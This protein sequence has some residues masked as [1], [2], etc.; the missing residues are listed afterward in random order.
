MTVR[1]RITTYYNQ[2]LLVVSLGAL[3]AIVT[4]VGAFYLGRL[5]SVRGWSLST[6]TASAFPLSS[7]S[8]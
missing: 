5:G 4:S 3:V 8:F 2:T 7:C 1:R 6:L